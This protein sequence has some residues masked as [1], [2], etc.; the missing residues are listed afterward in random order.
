MVKLY[1]ENWNELIHLFTVSKS[2]EIGFILNSWN[3]SESCLCV[4]MSGLERGAEKKKYEKT[5]NAI[6]FENHV[7]R[8]N[9]NSFGINQQTYRVWIDDIIEWSSTRFRDFG[10]GHYNTYKYHHHSQLN[11][12]W[13]Q[14]STVHHDTVFF[15]TF[16][17]RQLFFLIST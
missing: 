4:L 11:K 5:E 10:G 13:C 15:S 16:H 1:V 2:I 12:F 17:R 14:L 3:H 8:S 9:L 7:F 6:C